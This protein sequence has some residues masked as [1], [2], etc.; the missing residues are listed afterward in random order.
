[1]A[2]ISTVMVSWVCVF[3]AT[4]QTVPFKYVRFLVYQ[5]Y[6]NK[7]ASL[8]KRTQRP[9]KIKRNKQI[10]T[11][12]WS[13]SVGFALGYL[14]GSGKVKAGLINTRHRGARETKMWPWRRGASSFRGSRKHLLL[15]KLCEVSAPKSGKSE[16]LFQF[17]E[18][19]TTQKWKFC[20]QSRSKWQEIF[21]FVATQKAWPPNV[22]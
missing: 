20:Q 1:M 18:W 9:P 14:W 8:P 21:C 12:P 15:R 7:T 4:Y 3:T 5:L 13:N 22:A 19:L 2:I 6:L 16:S 10:Q 11:K 17:V